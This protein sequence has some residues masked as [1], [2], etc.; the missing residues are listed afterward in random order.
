MTDYPRSVQVPKEPVE[1]LDRRTL[2]PLMLMMQMTK[3]MKMMLVEKVAA[4]ARTDQRK[5]S[6]IAAA[7]GESSAEKNRM[8]MK[9]SA[10]TR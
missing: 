4:E 6:P 9:T 8:S 3:D 10:E 2:T 1:A 7:D 5:V